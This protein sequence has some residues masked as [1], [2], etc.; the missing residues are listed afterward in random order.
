MCDQCVDGYYFDRISNS[1]LKCHALCMTCYGPTFQNC[2]SC[3]CGS[4]SFNCNY[5]CPIGQFMDFEF[6]EC[7]NCH[8]S[9]QNCVGPLPS[10]CTACDT[11][12]CSLD[13]S[14][15]PSYCQMNDTNLNLT[16]CCPTGYFLL[17]T[18]GCQTCSKTCLNCF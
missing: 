4:N 12:I 5:N 6:H 11:S 9:C 13:N 2:N 1:C 16:T 17:E 10:D 14:Q 15:Y 7:R 3:Y 8:Y 18:L